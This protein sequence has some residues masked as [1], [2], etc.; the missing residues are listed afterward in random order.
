M[1][2]SAY[3]R[4]EDGGRQPRSSS[5]D[6]EMRE[7]AHVL[8]AGCRGPVVEQ[9][10]MRA[11]STYLRPAL[12]D[13]KSVLQHMRGRGL[14][15]R[16]RGPRHDLERVVQA[17]GR[18]LVIR[19]LASEHHGMQEPGDVD[20]PTGIG[21]RAACKESCPR[22]S[23]QQTGTGSRAV[24]MR[25]VSAYFRSAGSDRKPAAAPYARPR[26]PSRG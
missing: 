15:A 19:Q 16:A 21:S 26:P 17:R 6:T 18:R 2:S 23:G 25:V 12:G 9:L 13:R 22:T 1:T 11:M 3:F 5:V 14:H 10:G 4:P 24:C 20:R 7:H 8:R